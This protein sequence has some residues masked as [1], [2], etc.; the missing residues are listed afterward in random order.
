MLSRSAHYLSFRA[1]LILSLIITLSTLSAVQAA[2]WDTTLN[3]TS[4]PQTEAD[5][6]I[7]G[8]GEKVAF[9]RNNGEDWEI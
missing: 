3:I 4:S 8:N 2:P 9:A 6:C 5:A 1:A 7:S